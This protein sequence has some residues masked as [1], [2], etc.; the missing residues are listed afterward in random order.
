MSLEL[1]LGPMFSGKTGELFRRLRR[2]KAA[3]RTHLLIKW[4]GDVRY[5]TDKASTHDRD[6]LCASGTAQLEDV[7]DRAEACDV[8]GI[9]EG[10]FFPDLVRVVQQLLDAEKIV[11]I[12]A[13]DGDFRREPIGHTLQLVPRAESVIKLNAV[14]RMCGADAPFTRRTTSDTRV[15]LVGGA[16]TYEARCRA[17]FG[18]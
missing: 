1:I 15:E 11:I 6:M 5:S 13:L 8:I 2:H 3:G 18:K 14:C 16:D 10:Q 4:A 9:D 7:M 17:C 12:A